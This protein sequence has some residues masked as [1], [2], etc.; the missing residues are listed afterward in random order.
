VLQARLVVGDAGGLPICLG[1]KK[2]THLFS[3]AL[4]FVK[5]DASLLLFCT[6]HG[7]A[8]YSFRPALAGCK[9]LAFSEGGIE[10]VN[11]LPWFERGFPTGLPAHLLP[12]IVERLRGTPA[13]L[14]DRLAGVPDTVLTRRGP[15]P[16][17]IQENVGHLLDLEPLWRQ[18]VSDLARRR[19]ELAE[20]DLTNRRTHEAN[21]N[22]VPLAGLLATFRTARGV[23]VREFESF[24]EDGMSFTAIHP[25]LKASM[26]VTDLA[27]FVAEHDDY[28]LARISELLC[29]TSGPEEKPGQIDRRT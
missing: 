25:R 18:R 19:G 7:F 6:R 22:A 20:A 1:V 28:H 12:V 2:G 27:Y 8:R 29:A 11:R 24:P 17:S 5:I 4:T 16:W 13:R 23:L 15:G 10:M 14:A 26:N 21:H 3:E 9:V